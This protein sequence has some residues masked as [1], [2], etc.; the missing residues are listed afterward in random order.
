MMTAKGLNYEKVGNGC[1][2][3]TPTLTMQDVAGALG[4]ADISR[5]AYLYG[6][7][8]YTDDKTVLHE[9]DKL[10][11]KAVILFALKQGWKEPFPNDKK[12][13]LFFFLQM[14]RLVIN[15]LVGENFCKACNG[16]GYINKAKA[17]KCSC[18]DGK[19]PMKKAE[20][21]RFCGVHYDTW[22]TNWFSRY[23]KCV[24]HFKAWD[25]EI[26]FSIKNKLN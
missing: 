14:G 20:Q 7:L 6:L 4:M 13:S 17:K 16:T 12:R 8:K 11:Q 3:G 25:D 10:T 26:S 1:L 22:R 21:A 24:E 5:E 9:L 19:K 15:E 23:V 18:K 2:G